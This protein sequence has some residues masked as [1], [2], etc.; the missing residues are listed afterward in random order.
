MGR[1]QK[2][3]E[4]MK[5]GISEDDMLYGLLEITDEEWLISE[6]E[7]LRRENEW[8]I[9]HYATSK[10]KPNSLNM[11]SL[12]AIRDGISKEMNQALKDSE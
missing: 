11:S 1:F 7:W 6:N 5:Q 10:H 9:H 12:R 8:L 4:I 2:I 3:K